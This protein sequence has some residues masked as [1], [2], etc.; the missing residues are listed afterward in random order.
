M[1]QLQEQLRDSHHYPYK[2]MQWPVF[3]YCNAEVMICLWY[4]YDAVIYDTDMLFLVLCYILWHVTYT[5]VVTY[6]CT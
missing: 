2:A 1:R 5:L 4:D 3:I 6:Y